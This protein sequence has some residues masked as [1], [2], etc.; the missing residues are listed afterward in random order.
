MARQSHTSL[1]SAST[2]AHRCEFQ[3]RR[4]KTPTLCGSDDA[5]HIPRFG[6]RCERHHRSEYIRERAARNH[7]IIQRI[8]NDD[9]V[10]NAV[11]NAPEIF[12]FTAM[13]ERLDALRADIQRDTARLA[14]PPRQQ[15]L[16]EFAAD[17][18]NVHTRYTVDLVRKTVD[19][20]LKI[21]VPD[22]YQT[23]TLKTVGEIILDCRLSKKAASQMTVRYCSDDSVYQYGPGI[24]ARLLNAVWQFIKGSE[25]KDD[26]CAILRSEME[27]NIDMC[28]QGNLSRL[29][30]ILSGYMDSIIME[31]IP[32]QLQRRMAE[33][34]A[35][36]MNVT[37]K[38]RH[39]LNLLKELTIPSQ[40]W[41][42]WLEQLMA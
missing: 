2:M 23:D 20:V 13:R 22:E 31:T 42:A 19:Q 17:R 3:D 24:Y 33:I 1:R 38:T 8:A 16:A 15:P 29:C 4:F 25:H 41:G 5:L 40:E 21:P 18:Q 27:D 7:E 37:K 28:A 12:D 30:N 32:E 39:A 6:W 26:L 36:D 11:D 34:A 14:A 35:S 10:P 9:N